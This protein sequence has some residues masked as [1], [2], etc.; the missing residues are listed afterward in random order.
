MLALRRVIALPEQGCL[1]GASGQVTVNAVDA[2]VQAPT[3]EPAGAPFMKVVIDYRLPGLVPLQELG[4]LLAPETRRVFHRALV[5]L[6]I[7]LGRD[8]R[9]A[10][11][12]GNFM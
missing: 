7:T 5:H 3:G 1:L 4:G 2:H 11:I 8:V 6:A 10:E 12:V 9:I